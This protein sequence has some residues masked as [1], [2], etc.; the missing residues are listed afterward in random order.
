MSSKNKKPETLLKGRRR[1][2]M[3]IELE[4]IILYRGGL[5]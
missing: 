4:K 5:Q 1:N 2:S 3:F